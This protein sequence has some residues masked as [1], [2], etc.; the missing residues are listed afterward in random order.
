MDPIY[1]FADLLKILERA[2]QS[3]SPEKRESVSHTVE[4]D[5]DKRRLERVFLGS[6]SDPFW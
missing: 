3:Q 1:D 2:L 4:E 5:A 6:F